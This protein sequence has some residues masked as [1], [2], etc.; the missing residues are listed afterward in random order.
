MEILTGKLLIGLLACKGRV[1]A[2]GRDTLGKTLVHLI[3]RAQ[4]RADT[5]ATAVINSLVNRTYCGAMNV[6]GMHEGL[7]SLKRE[8]PLQQQRQRKGE[9]ER[10]QEQAQT[11]ER[12]RGGKAVFATYGSRARK[13]RG[14]LNLH[15]IRASC[16][17]KTAN[18]STLFPDVGLLSAT[19][20]HQGVE[21]SEHNVL[22]VRALRRSLR[23]DAFPRCSERMKN[24]K[25]TR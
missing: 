16:P 3:V 9:R 15:K 17:T 13:H 8:C 20:V 25:K 1:E 10:E 18:F 21:R 19:L 24:K 6:H 11:Q 22:I 23:H 12:E 5:L 14:R 2:R 4:R 7:V